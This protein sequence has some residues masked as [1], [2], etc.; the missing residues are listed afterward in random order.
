MLEDPPRDP[1]SSNNNHHNTNMLQPRPPTSGSPNYSLSAS[2]SASAYQPD[3][4]KLQCGA[5]VAE[6]GLSKDVTSSS[7]SSRR[8]VS[9]YSRAPGPPQPGNH[10]PADGNSNNNNTMAMSRPAS[11]RPVSGSRL[12]S[13]PGTSPPG[14][15][16]TRAAGGGGFYV[17]RPGTGKLVYQ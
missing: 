8:P 5:P 13:N 10:L 11:G 7:S 14:V 15:P 16:A 4:S 1:V 9:A 2:K 12:N 3:V 17:R 6:L